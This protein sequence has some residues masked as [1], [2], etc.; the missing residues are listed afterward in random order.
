MLKLIMRIFY[1]DKIYTTETDIFYE[2]YKYICGIYILLSLC[3]NL[4]II[5]L[6]LIGIVLSFFIKFRTIGL[7]FINIGIVLFILKLREQEKYIEYHL[8]GIRTPA[9]KRRDRIVYF[10]IKCICLNGKALGK[11]E[12][13]T[14]KHQN[15]ELY[16]DLLSE[17]CLHRCYFYSLEIARIIKD[18]FLIW[19][20]IE[21]PFYD[22]HK[23]YAH[24]V[25]LR[26]G[27]IYDSNML[28]SEKY[29]DFIKLYKFKLY[30]WWNYNIYSQIDFRETEREAFR[31]WCRE[32]NVYEF[33]EF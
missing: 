16:H 12:W 33:E 5:I 28:Q 8:L 24:A 22:E 13:K 3:R 21:E 4:C 2:M 20:A 1:H 29:E 14:I 11:K 31:K 30:K 9:E 27:Y 18:S 25:I 32:N 19:G 7:V 6:I 23:Y 10:I 26:N 15:I 17:K